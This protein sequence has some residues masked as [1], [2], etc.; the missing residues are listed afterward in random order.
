MRRSP[1]LSS[2][3]TKYVSATPTAASETFC[4]RM[5]SSPPSGRPV[6]SEYQIAGTARM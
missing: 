4:N 3:A 1:R 2:S 6:Q 5:N